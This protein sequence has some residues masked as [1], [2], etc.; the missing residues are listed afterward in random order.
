VGLGVTAWVGVAAGVVVGPAAVGVAAGWLLV[1]L[2]AGAAAGP[3]AA[4]SANAITDMK[5]RRVAIPLPSRSP[6]PREASVARG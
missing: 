5:T 6:V 3:H 2:P 1:E 4:T